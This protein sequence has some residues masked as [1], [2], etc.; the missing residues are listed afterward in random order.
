MLDRAK[1]RP[2]LLLPPEQMSIEQRIEQL[3]ER[4]SES[5]AVGFEDLFV[6]ADSR[7]R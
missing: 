2:K 6:D 1:A 7:L 3:L 4:L 5:E